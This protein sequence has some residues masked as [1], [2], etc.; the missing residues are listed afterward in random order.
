MKNF[1]NLFVFFLLFYL[2]FTVKT[3]AAEQIL[4]LPKPTIDKETKVK[5]EKSKN[6][7]P[8]K[9]TNKKRRKD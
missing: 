8:E 6:I 4:P 1:L 7:Y 3:I 9:K 2:I 5:V